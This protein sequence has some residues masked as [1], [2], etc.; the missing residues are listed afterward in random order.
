MLNTPVQRYS[1]I[2]AKLRARLSKMVDESIF[3]QMIKAYNVSE[4]VGILQ[5]TDYST[6]HDVFSKTGD[7][8]L[9]ELELFKKE[10]ALYSEMR[11][12]VDEITGEFVQALCLRFEIENL[13]NTLRLFF[14]RKIRERDIQDSVHYILYTPIINDLHIEQILHAEGIDDVILLLKSTPYAAILQE[15]WPTVITDRSLFSVEVALDHYFYKN[16]VANANSL[17]GRD[18]EQARRLV[19]V[20]IDLQNINWIMRF[21]NF[22]RLPL[23]KVMTSIIPSG[24]NLKPENIEDFY[25]AHTVIPM[26]QTIV[27]SNYPGLSALILTDEPDL[28]A[29]LLLIEHVLEHIMR[30]EVKRTLSGYPFSIGIILAYFTLKTFEMNKIKAILNAKQYGIPEDRI[31]GVI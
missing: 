28:T 8:K 10:I 13:K 21:K 16:L 17:D 4:A 30:Y 29:R 11:R 12:Y 27:K 9:A 25:S 6:L 23:E 19:G 26:L 24:Y 22:Y 14:D 20:E 5:N 15:H 31:R 3:D 7:L 2:N 18:K 1:F